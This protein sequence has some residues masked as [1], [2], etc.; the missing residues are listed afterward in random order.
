M[1]GIFGVFGKNI[2]KKQAEQSF[3]AIEHRGKDAVGK[4]E[5]KERILMH[6]LHAV[7]G[8]VKQ[9]LIAEKDKEKSIFMTNCEIY[10][11]KELKKKYNLNAKNDAELLFL[12]FKDKANK[13]VEQILEELDGVYAFFY[14]KQ[15]KV[16]LAR[17]ILGEKPLCYVHTK[18]VFAF[19]SEA[20]ALEMYGTP[21]HLKPTEILEYNTETNKI[22]ITERS[23]FKTP[24][25]T[26]ETKEQII[27]K[28]ETYFTQAIQKRAEDI[29]HYGILFSGGIDSTLVA[30]ASK[31]IKKSF[32]CYTA[33]FADGNTR[34]APDLLQA[35]EVAKRL[36]FP[37]KTKILTLE[38]TETA[39]KEVINIIETTDA[40]KVGVA[41]PFYVCAK[42]AA[43]DGH[44]VLF[45][46]LG[47]EELFA[48]YQRHLDVY[49]NKGNVNAECLKGL[50]QLWERDLYRDDLIT[51][52]NTIELR[53]PFLDD[54]LIKYALSI[55]AKEKIDHMQNK[56]IL[57][58]FAKEIGIPEQFAERKKIAAQY[59]SNFDKALEKL[60]KKA[61]CKSKKE[62]LER[63]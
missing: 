19:A 48:G 1:C 44:K 26:A 8:N 23:F 34:D 7:V 31:K 21:K 56:I 16:I 62:Y 52:A 39:V 60:A 59:G 43:E 54:D 53:L 13:A 50:A 36:N 40:I 42:M 15:S 4:I 63:I 9:P 41:L 45:S 6:C 51:M 27:Q 49:K 2:N 57:R 18:D 12:L 24:K 58:E 47:S 33:A 35:Q 28:L 55:P 37:L 30:F 5:E 10:N 17:D 46:G 20:K 22:K 14:Q 32:T 29:E 38:E 25:E 3:A 11:W 61:G